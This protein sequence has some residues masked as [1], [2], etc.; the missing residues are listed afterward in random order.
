MARQRS[1]RLAAEEEELAASRRAAADSVRPPEPEAEA[2]PFCAGVAAVLGRIKL[3]RFVVLLCTKHEL[4]MDGLMVCELDDLM[5]MELLHVA[6]KALLAELC[7]LRMKTQTHSSAEMKTWEEDSVASWLV[8]TLGTTLTKQEL[9]GM[10]SVELDGDDLAEAS[11]DSLKG[12][13]K[14]AA[15]HRPELDWV[16]MRAAVIAAR[17]KALGMGQMEQVGPELLFDRSKPLE[18]Q[19]WVGQQGDGRRCAVS[20]SAARKDRRSTSCFRGSG[21]LADVLTSSTTISGSR[22]RL[23]DGIIS[24]W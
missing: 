8:T 11:G 19:V 10:L 7:R 14:R 2:R 13:C 15:K 1:T 21:R 17:D 24:L 5:E 12:L 22:R 4:D 18:F 9:E 23:M 6:A 16:K 3:E 20:K